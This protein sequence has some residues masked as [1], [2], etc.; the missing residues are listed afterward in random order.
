MEKYPNGIYTR[1]IDV[2]V[3]IRRHNLLESILTPTG[4]VV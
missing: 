2:A 1:V 3:D 4:L